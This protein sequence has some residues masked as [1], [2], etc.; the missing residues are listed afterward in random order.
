MNRLAKWTAAVAIVILMAGSALAGDAIMRGKVKSTI[1]DKNEF[2]LDDAN[3]KDHTFT[4]G[5]NFI[6]NRDGKDVK[7]ADL[8]TGDDVSVCYDAG[9][10]KWTVHY[11]LV[12]E[13]AAK[14]LELGRGTV[15]SYEAD[16]GEL[17]LKDLNGKD[18]TFAVPVT[19]KVEVNT[20]AAKMADI[21]VGEMATIVY[22][23]KDNKKP[24][25]V[26]LT[27]QRKQ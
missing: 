11:V 9:L 5:D 27:V 12:H 23:L 18:W 20:Q 17:G 3:G 10:L 6:I 8:K 24:T 4:L 7:F 19:S 21:K 14:N 1:P 25:M 22:N 26:S 13:G 16:K 15:K 2:V